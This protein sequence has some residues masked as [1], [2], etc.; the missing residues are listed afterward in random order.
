MN[1]TGATAKRPRV[2]NK[3]DSGSVVCGYPYEPV[4]EGLPLTQRIE[5]RA[6][7]CYLMQQGDG[8]SG[9]RDGE[10]RNNQG[11]GHP[12]VVAD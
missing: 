7:T 9:N 11:G 12:V 8:T 6:R 3:L 10:E 2:I 5:S 4:G 1:Q